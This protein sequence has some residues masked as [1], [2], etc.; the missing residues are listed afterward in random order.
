MKAELKKI[1]SELMRKRIAST[2]R[3]HIINT[4]PLKLNDC[5]WKFELDNCKNVKDE[6]E[7]CSEC[8]TNWLLSECEV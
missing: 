6:I 1:N 2:A 8:W 3:G 7:I 4:C 5:T